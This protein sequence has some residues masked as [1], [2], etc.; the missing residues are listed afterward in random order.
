MTG[1]RLL[2]SIT[3]AGTLSL[4]AIGAISTWR[5]TRMAPSWYAPPDPTSQAVLDLAD[6]AEYRLIEE[7]QKIRPPD[8]WTLRVEDSQVNAW[9]SARLPQWVRHDADFTW[10]ESI[11]TP[12][13]QTDG[14]GIRVALPLQEN[15][16]SFVVTARLSP[17]LDDGRLFLQLDRL[18]LGR[19]G[20]PGEP[21]TRLA[22]FLEE[23]GGEEISA[24][25]IGDLL[26]VL[27]G[28]TPIDPI[29]SLADD[30]QVE[31]MQIRLGPGRVDL[32]CRTLPPRRD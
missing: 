16:A 28:R 8:E 32:T 20:L 24:L 4:L 29:M 18:W 1:R 3:L 11:G 15:D 5:L 12:Q 19:I 10:P 25:Q 13:I 2:K 14:N 22:E 27:A 23:H 31:L 17:R 26:D 21:L 9:L 7:A 30:R 6:R